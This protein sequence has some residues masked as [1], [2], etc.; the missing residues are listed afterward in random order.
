MHLPPFSFSYNGGQRGSIGTY[1]PFMMEP[2]DYYKL[3]KGKEKYKLLH[4]SLQIDHYPWF[5]IHTSN[6]HFI[7]I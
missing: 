5:C 3:I 7:L 1:T 6:R 4:Q 2:L